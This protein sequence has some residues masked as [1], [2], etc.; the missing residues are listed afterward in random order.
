M[1]RRLTVW[2]NVCEEETSLE[3]NLESLCYIQTLVNMRL[4]NAT[5]SS[6]AEET[7]A[8]K[9]R[10]YQ[11]RKQFSFI[12]FIHIYMR[13]MKKMSNFLP[14]KKTKSETLRLMAKIF[15]KKLGNF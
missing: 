5:S 11:N 13:A 7:A 9:I 8:T 1:K 10:K 15:K 6:N 2:D 12:R 14:K 4:S 3:V